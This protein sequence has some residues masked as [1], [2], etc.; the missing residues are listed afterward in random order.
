MKIKMRIN[1]GLLDK[2][3]CWEEWVKPGVSLQKVRAKMA[4]EG[5]FINP[6]TGKPPNIGAIRYAAFSH[7]VT[8]S[9]ED[10][11]EA[12]KQFSYLKQT[13]EAIVVDDDYWGAWMVEMIDAM[14]PKNPRLRNQWIA[15]HGL[16]K[17][18]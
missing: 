14:Y 9:P 4:R 18:A 10:V 17:Y 1:G 2:K 7:V 6:A 3:Y 12:R 16:Q 15:K 13:T 8:G 11:K 5:K